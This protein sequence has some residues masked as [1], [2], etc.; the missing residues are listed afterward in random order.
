MKR[1]FA[2]GHGKQKQDMPKVVS[3]DELRAR[4]AEQEKTLKSLEEA[5]AEHFDELMATPDDAG[6]TAAMRAAASAVTDAKEHLARLRSSL[7]RAETREQEALAA[8]QAQIRKDNLASIATQRRI[9]TRQALELSVRFERFVDEW[10]RFLA[11]AERVRGLLLPEM[12]TRG[13]AHTGLMPLMLRAAAERELYRLGGAGTSAMAL[14]DGGT[15][16]SMAAPG[17]TSPPSLSMIAKADPGSTQSLE[18]YVEN[19]FASLLNEPLRSPVAHVAAIPASSTPEPA[20]ATQATA[21]GDVSSDEDSVGYQAEL[22]RMRGDLPPTPA[23]PEPA[24]A[25]PEVDPELEAMVSELDEATKANLQEIARRNA[26]D[27]LGRLFAPKE[28]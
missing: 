11:S 3:S 16:R 23:D 24:P 5:E 17:C 20:S 28:S 4:L 19:L 22:A 6:K 12:Q 18:Q 27:A 1:G 7:T 26:A 21:A 2:A 25:E 15:V 13:G 8:A 14:H 9:M 10:A